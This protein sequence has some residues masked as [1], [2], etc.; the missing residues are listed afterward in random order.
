MKVATPPVPVTAEPTAAPSTVKFTV[1][2]TTPAL[3][4]FR[5]SVAVKVT[6]PDDPNAT[7]LGLTLF[8]TSVVGT[9]AVTVRVLEAVL[10]VSPNPP[11]AVAVTAFVV[12]FL[13]PAVVAVTFTERIQLAF[14]AML[15]PVKV[16]VVAPAVGAKVLPQVLLAEGDAATCTP[17]GNGSLNAALVKVVAFALL[18]VKVSVEVPPTVMLEGEKDLLIVGGAK[19]PTVYAALSVQT[20]PPAGVHDGVVML[21]VSVMVSP[22]SAVAGAVKWKVSNTPVGELEA[23]L[24]KEPLVA[25]TVVMLPDFVNVQFPLMLEL[26]SPPL[27]PFLIANVTVKFDPVTSLMLVAVGVSRDTAILRLSVNVVC[28]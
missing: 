16:I 5:V 25:S 28:A 18:S 17:A 3:V 2:P 12:L 15:P 19:M 6:G 11:V 9:V 22:V 27:L 26:L 14:A 20:L 24:V 8:R 4:S 13:L 23:R 21:D 1:A 7:E 10:P